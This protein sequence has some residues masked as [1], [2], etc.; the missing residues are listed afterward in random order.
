MIHFYSKNF[1]L[2]VTPEHDMF[3]KRR[4]RYWTNKREWEFILAFGDD[5]TDE[6]VF[7][8]LPQDAY[9]VKVGFG[10]SA[11]KYYLR[12]S[13]EVRSFIKELAKKE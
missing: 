2:L 8:A 3:A 11:A 10:A 4:G 12:S 6:D 7:K 9:S 1:D 5:R 13:V